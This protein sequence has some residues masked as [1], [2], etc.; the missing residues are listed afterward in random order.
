MDTRS[1]RSID[2]TQRSQSKSTLTNMD[3]ATHEQPIDLSYLPDDFPPRGLDDAIKHF[4]GMELP[5]AVR[6]NN[7]KDPLRS[8]YLTQHGQ[9][10]NQLTQATL[11]SWALDSH[12]EIWTLDVN[13]ER[14]IVKGSPNAGFVRGAKWIYHAWSPVLRDFEEKPIAF[15]TIG[16][17]QENKPQITKAKHGKNSNTS[18]E[19][20]T[21]GTL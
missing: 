20:L 10:P 2:Q 3:S 16:N 7:G 4:K 17:T 8:V 21:N 9:R 6:Y 13:G 19:S 5:F 15:S 12:E 14:V 1:K 18:P 11:W